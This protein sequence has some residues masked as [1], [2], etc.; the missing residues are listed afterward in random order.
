MVFSEVEAVERSCLAV[1]TVAD[2][3]DAIRTFCIVADLPYLVYTKEGYYLKNEKLRKHCGI[4]IAAING[5][6]DEIG[7]EKEQ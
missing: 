3:H 2:L 4:A 7:K 5:M 1:F 6:L